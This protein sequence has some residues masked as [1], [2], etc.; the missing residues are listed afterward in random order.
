[1]SRRSNRPRV[2]PGPLGEEL[3]HLHRRIDAVEPQPSPGVL[4]NQTTRG[5]SRV[6]LRPP[7]GVTSIRVAT[8]SEEH[9]D[10]LVCLVHGVSVE[11]AKPESLRTSILSDNR[12]ANATDPIVSYAHPAG[13]IPTEWGQKRVAT[14]TASGG[15]GA[16]GQF[17]QYI[18]P[19]Y[20]DYATTPPTG[21][22]VIIGRLLEPLTLE[23][24]GGA[25][26]T[27]RWIDMNN[28]RREWSSVPIARN[29]ATGVTTIGVDPIPLGLG[30]AITQTT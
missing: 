7:A 8:V 23:L 10:Y 22:E 17:D 30:L 27:F 24:W 13:V 2:F 21:R 25:D 5:V 12:S 29:I 26:R 11:V 20:I 15:L 3:D 9:P 4:T 28:A 14:Y 16:S 19:P 18:W 1:M 6:P